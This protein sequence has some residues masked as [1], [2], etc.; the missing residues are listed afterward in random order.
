MTVRPPKA[1]AARAGSIKTQHGFTLLEM[2]IVMGLI[3]LSYLAFML[4]GFGSKSNV[5]QEV[6]NLSSRIRYAYHLAATESRYYRMSFEL[7][8]DSASYVVEVSDDP[9]YVAKVDPEAEKDKETELPEDESEDGETAPP[10]PAFAESEDEL[11][12]PY[13]LD[14]DSKICSI[15]VEHQTEAIT[16]GHAELHF[17]PR[18]QTEFAVIQICDTDQTHV[19]TLAVNPVTGSI[20]VFDEAKNHE[21][22]L[23][24]MQ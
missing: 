16:A 21:D 11:L 10:A 6:R 12:E 20:A 4:F 14:A 18:G 8:E 15:F 3:A 13:T 2:M 7:S 5:R 9:I 1:L 17:F 22:V 23:E 24:E 19:M